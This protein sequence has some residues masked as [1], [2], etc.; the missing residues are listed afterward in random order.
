[1]LVA[2]AGGIYAASRRR[3]VTAD[4]V[5][6]VPAPAAAR[7][8]PGL[9]RIDMNIDWGSLGL[10]AIV[11]LAVTVVVV[12]LVVVRH[13]GLLRPRGNEPDAVQ[14]LSPAVGTAVGYAC[15]AAVALIVLYG[16]W[17]V[18]SKFLLSLF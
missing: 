2:I 4:N 17:L 10:V 8:R 6:D 13:G 1:M 15:V 12:A 14:V 5:N 9:R 16:L 11:S 18:S 7:A 3:P